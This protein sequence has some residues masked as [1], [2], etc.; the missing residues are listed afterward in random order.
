M[1]AALLADPSVD[2]TTRAAILARLK[3]KPAGPAG[4]AVYKRAEV[5]RLFSCTPRT[6]SNMVQQ[7]ELLTI[8]LA[9]RSRAL[10]IRADSVAALLAR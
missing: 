6:V 7:G 5:A 1:K 10:G 8:K 2:T 9:G 4:P 3:D